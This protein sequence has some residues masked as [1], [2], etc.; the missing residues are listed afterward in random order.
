MGI[1]QFDRTYLKTNHAPVNEDG[2]LFFRC[3]GVFSV[4]QYIYEKI[5]DTKEALCL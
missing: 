5:T 3:L 4:V 2:C 1:N